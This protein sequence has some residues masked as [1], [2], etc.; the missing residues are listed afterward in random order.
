MTSPV[1]HKITLNVGGERYE[2]YLHTL[3]RFPDTLLGDKA[4][5]SRYYCP[6]TRHY[7]FDRSRVF[8]DAILFYY[9]SNGLLCC[10]EE[11][12]LDLFIE[13]CQF[14]G[15]PEH[16]I[17]TL[18][19]EVLVDDETGQQA[20]KLS[21]EDESGVRAKIWNLLENPETSTFAKIYSLFSLFMIVVAV[22][23]TCIES[24]PSLQKRNETFENN[25][26]AVNELALNSWFLFELLLTVK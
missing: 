12:P 1:R 17:D 10:P 4:K 21:H 23:S 2:T 19:P 8:F 13:E 3:K 22:V 6:N 5:R 15:L 20:D 9:Q 24:V 14:F 7:F 25:P 11:V 26:W 18:R 16:A